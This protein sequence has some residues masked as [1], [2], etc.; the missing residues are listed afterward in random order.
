MRHEIAENNNVGRLED[1]H[2]RFVLALEYHSILQ[3][4]QDLVVHMILLCPTQIQNHHFRL[5]V[6]DGRRYVGTLAILGDNVGVWILQV[7]VHCKMG[8]PDSSLL[9]AVP[10]DL[11]WVHW[12]L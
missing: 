2:P 5:R 10:N 6:A 3:V 11:A 1:D 8:L 4:L 7:H 12:P 9:V